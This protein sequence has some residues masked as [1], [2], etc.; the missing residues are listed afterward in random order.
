MTAMLPDGRRLG[1]H[2]PLGAGMVKAVERAR[3]IGATA[4]QIFGDNPTAWKRR[5][6][7]PT[8]QAAFR[9][10]LAAYDIGPV[11]VHAAYLVNLAGADEE[12][13]ASSVEVLAQ[14]LRG[15]PGF[16]ARFV[17]VHTGSHRDTTVEAGIERLASGVAA[18]LAD[19]PDA[20]DA[21]V[22]V[23]ENSAG[24]GFPVGVTVEELAAIAEAIA[25]RGIE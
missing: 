6:E 23:L 14:E 10:R 16:G 18:A 17:N 3:A 25:R 1:P 19:V 22:L 2:V 8:E 12:F 21:P 20:P 11:A 4:I 24:G 13:F 15:A 5:S 7:P 9:E